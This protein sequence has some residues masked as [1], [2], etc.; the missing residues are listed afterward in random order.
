MPINFSAGSIQK[1]V[2][3]YPAQE[4]LPTAPGIQLWTG[5]ARMAKPSP[6]V[7]PARA[8]TSSP[9][10]MR[11]PGGSA[12]VVICLHRL[13]A[14]HAHAVEFAAIQQ[15]LAKAEI[16]G[17]GRN[18]AAAAGKQLR[19]R[20]DVPDPRPF[21]HRRI[22]EAVE[23]RFRHVEAGVDHMQRRKDAALQEL[24]ER[25][26]G[27]HLDDPAEHVDAPAIF[28]DLAGLMGERQARQSGNE[29]RQ[30]RVAPVR[31]RVRPAV[32]HMDRTE[33]RTRR[34]RPQGPAPDT[35]NPFPDR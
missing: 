22:D 16:V 15:H 30:R 23:L 6:K 18:Q 32:K 17:R 11:I 33:F 10:K 26:T 13:R 27:S 2:P 12:F 21:R 8:P 3:Q 5:S 29:I 20:R 4:K 35:Q 28:M 34:R 1:Y 7:V 25:L 14:E 24:V 31:G 9:P 19:R